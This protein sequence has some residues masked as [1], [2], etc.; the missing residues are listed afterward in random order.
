MLA[1]SYQNFFSIPQ[2]S[3]TRLALAIVGPMVMM[4]APRIEEAKKIRVLIS[5][6]HVDNIIKLSNQEKFALIT[7]ESSLSFNNFSMSLSSF[8][9]GNPVVDSFDLN[10]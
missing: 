10:L 6:S 8:H 4:L 5:G 9:F 1:F 3:Q 7:S 2:D